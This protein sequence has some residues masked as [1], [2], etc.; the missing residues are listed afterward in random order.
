[1]KLFLD[2]ITLE[3]ASLPDNGAGSSRCAC[4]AFFYQHFSLLEQ[5]NVTGR[6][7]KAYLSGVSFQVNTVGLTYQMAVAGSTI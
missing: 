1:M 2:V 3:N 4:A 7:L 5:S 6:L